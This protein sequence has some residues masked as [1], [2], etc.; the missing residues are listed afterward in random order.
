LAVWAFVYACYR[1]YYALGGQAGMIGRPVSEARFR[2]VNAVGAA[3]LMLAAIVP[4]TVLRHGDGWPRRALLAGC[5]LAAVAFCMHAFVDGVLRILSLSGVHAVSYPPGL[6][7]T[8]HRR[9]A[10]LQD[11]LFNEP[12]FFVEGCLWA[13]VGSLTLRTEASRR[14]WLL[15]AVAGC[16]LATA[17]GLLTGL[18][19]IESVRLG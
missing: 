2:V 8:I 1:G 15:S 17:L 5:W 7:V 10:D 12:W 16:L 14:R 9:T 6:W 18:G 3:I 11:L 13:L 19:A 4:L